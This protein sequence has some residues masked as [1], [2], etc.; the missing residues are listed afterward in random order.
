MFL[1]TYSWQ[2][3]N[4][5]YY[6]DDKWMFQKPD[7]YIIAYKDK[8]ISC[9]LVQSDVA[10]ELKKLQQYIFV[11]SLM[12]NRVFITLFFQILQALERYPWIAAAI[13]SMTLEI[14]FPFQIKYQLHSLDYTYQDGKDEVRH[15]VVISS[16]KIVV[17]LVLRNNFW[18][19]LGS[20]AHSRIGISGSS[21]IMVHPY[22]QRHIQ[23]K[24]IKSPSKISVCCM[25]M[26]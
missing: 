6:S 14:D 4:V 1:S 24:F 7:M 3:R 11:D 19:P 23:S 8:P 5:L 25:Q 15:Q 16:K 12:H 9:I 17:K 13:N 26:T 21:Y 10:D 22:L 20:E 18:T 2:V